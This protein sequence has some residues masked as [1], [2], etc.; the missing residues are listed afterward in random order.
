MLLKRLTHARWALLAGVLLVGCEDDVTQLG[1]RL[2][3]GGAG[4]QHGTVPIAGSCAGSCQRP[5]PVCGDG[6]VQGEEECDDGNTKGGD[7]CAADCLSIRIGFT[8]IEGLP[9]DSVCGDAVIA[10]NE[11]CDDGNTKGGDGCAADC[12]SL[13]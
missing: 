6:V 11:V 9:C 7:G 1:Q 8:C 4:G 3:E 5:A 12:L 10:G 13:D 2:G